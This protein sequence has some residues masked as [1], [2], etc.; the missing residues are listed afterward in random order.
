MMTEVYRERDI[1]PAL[2]DALADMPVVVVT[3][4]RQ[5]GKST[6]LQRLSRI[7]DRRYVSLDDF[8][9][10]EAARRN[11]E[12]F[13][14]GDQPITV[15]EAQKCP[16]LLSVIKQMVDRDRIP[17]RF[18][19]SGSANFALLRGITESLA[20]RAVY[21]TL[22]PF[23]R[24][25][26]AGAV[27][28]EPFLVRFFRSPEIAERLSVRPLDPSEVVLGGM[29]TVCLGDVRN[30]ALWFKGYEQTYLERDVR[31][32]SQVADLIAFRNLLL[33]TALR[34]GQLL[35]PSELARDA[36]LNTA[37][38]SRYLGLMEASCVIRRI[39]PYLANRASRLIKSPKLYLSD[40]GL[41]CYLTGIDSLDAAV[42]EPA[43]SEPL[44]GAMFETYVAQNLS[45]ILEACWPRARLL[46]WNVQGRHEVD[47]II[48]VG[49]DTLAIEV[50]AAS[51]WNDRDLSGLRAFLSATP[52]CRAAI[53]AHNGTEAVR[54]DDRIW[55]I[56]LGLLLS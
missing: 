1:S 4:M 8:A 55:A 23:N 28:D 25:E 9:H 33:L 52:R 5:V 29:P 30:P 2:L 51:R 15:D 36:K 19:L 11:P 39:G 31:E 3:G 49:R 6:L 21:L 54:L 17:G 44:R 24:R 42:N 37:T 26:I 47:F 50:K 38:A 20:G 40:S 27:S 56:P 7:Q 32:L 45:G 53:L 46:F 34:T 22:Y 13:L 35:K 43:V 18:L 48:E 12:A 16:E 10:L 41:A 14:R